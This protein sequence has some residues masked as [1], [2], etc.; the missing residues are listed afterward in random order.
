MNT[1]QNPQNGQNLQNAQ[2]GQPVPPP[3][4]QQGQQSWDYP[5]GAPA[6][7]EQE[8]A[9]KKTGLIIGLVIAAAVLI[10]IIALVLT[11]V[12]GGSKVKSYDDLKTEVTR[13]SQ[14]NGLQHCHNVEDTLLADSM[15]EEFGEDMD[16]I[17]GM[18][19]CST[20]DFSSLEALASMSL[21]E[22][23]QL[24][25]GA[26]AAEGQS[27]DENAI[28]QDF[29]SNNSAGGWMVGEGRWAVFGVTDGDTAIKDALMDELKG[30]DLAAN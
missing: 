12:L 17:E 9:K 10:A 7:Q 13:I 6:P 27:A 5:G 4:P 23:P 29:N 22:E 15:K 14:A 1:P 19:I 28:A 30:K 8:P 26:Y 16:K 25:M 11:T 2:N 3:A 18:V 20:T 24:V 21:D